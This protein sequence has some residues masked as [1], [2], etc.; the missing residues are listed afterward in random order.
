M[1]IIIK[2]VPLVWNK[3]ESEKKIYN[4]D[5][6]NR[7]N[8]NNYFLTLVGHPKNLSETLRWMLYVV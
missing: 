8:N 6:F 3:S 1:Y 7:L 2:C 5:S 4:Y